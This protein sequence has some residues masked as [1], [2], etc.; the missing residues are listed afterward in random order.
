[1]NE[2]MVKVIRYD[3][4]RP[5]QVLEGFAPGPGKPAPLYTY[6]VDDNGFPVYEMSQQLAGVV[7]NARADRYRLYKSKPF[8]VKSVTP[9]GAAT[10]PTLYSWCYTKRT[11]ANG[12]DPENNEKK[13]KTVFDWFE[14]SK[15]N[16]Y[17]DNTR[18]QI[19]HSAVKDA[20]NP[21]SDLQPHCVEPPA[22]RTQP[23]IMRELKEK[24]AV[25]LP[26]GEEDVKV[27]VSTIRTE[28]GLGKGGMVNA[29]AFVEIVKAME[30]LIKKY[31]ETE[32]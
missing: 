28:L 32:E 8:M 21:T 18:D 12:E 27:H 14:G 7:C 4:K 24:L 2:Q 20:G 16:P 15:E 10:Y 1:M 5:R 3:G 23:E 30:A 6:E 25:L 17:F 26:G 19:K 9:K 29:T 22:P 31:S 11:E 13:F